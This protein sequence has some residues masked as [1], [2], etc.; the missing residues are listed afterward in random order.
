MQTSLDIAVIGAGIGGLTTA[1]ALRQRGIDAYVYESAPALRASGAGLV[2]SPNAMQ[3]LRRL[4]LA[5]RV[6]EAGQPIERA[7]LHDARSG[8]LQ[9][10]DIGVDYGEPTVAIQRRR[11]HEILVGDLP[12]DRVRLNAACESIIDDNGWPTI[13]FTNGRA[14]SPDIIV[15]A[16]GLRS[17]V[18]SFVAPHAVVRY[19]G[20]TSFRGIASFDL[21]HP[22]ARTSQEVWA[23]HCR[24][25]FAPVAPGLV[26]WFASLDAP[27]GETQEP[28]EIV[29][30]L[31]AMTSSFPEPA[32]WLLEATA[33]VDILR[34]DMYDLQPFEGWSRSRVVLLGDAA[35]ATTPNLGQGAAQAIEDALVLADRIASTPRAQDALRSYEEIR[36]PKTRF[37]VV[38]SMQLGRVAH[39][40]NP[41]GRAM[42]NFAV[43]F[44][45][46]VV[47]RRQLNRMYALD[48]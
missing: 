9:R 44:T 28:E 14:T 12:M 35:H 13:T 37:I 7:E 38:R 2:L 25:G 40:A 10:I 32:T 8:L 20:Q 3:V 46:A 17:I 41:F 19:S 5:D 45:P 4:G 16:D 39:V 26:Y 18:R 48:Y 23:P 11:L 27:A 22:L 34:T 42:R 6:R 15:G 33:P 43:R 47:A 29:S 30:Q 1:I 21:P 36:Q 31:R 24:F